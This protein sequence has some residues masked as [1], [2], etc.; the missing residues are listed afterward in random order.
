M[1]RIFRRLEVNIGNKNGGRKL[2][3]RK[4]SEE[5]HAWDFR[6]LSRAAGECS[7]I[8][9]YGE[10]PPVLGVLGSEAQWSRP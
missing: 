5:G 10:Q 4:G 3:A 1:N 2:R 6:R 9:T 8:F 7:R